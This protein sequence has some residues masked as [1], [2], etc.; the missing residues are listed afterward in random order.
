MG[1]A[2][3]SAKRASQ[4]SFFPPFAPSFGARYLVR[5]AAAATILCVPDRLHHQRVYLLKVSLRNHNHMR[6]RQ[7]L[8]LQPY[9]H[10]HSIYIYKYLYVNS[11]HMYIY[12]YIYKYLYVNSIHMY[13][14]IHTI[15]VY[16]YNIHTYVCKDM[17]MYSKHIS[18]FQGVIRPLTSLLVFAVVPNPL[19][20]NSWKETYWESNVKFSCMTPSIQISDLHKSLKFTHS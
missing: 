5:M 13:I 12:M 2:D 1:A 10:T 8:R 6:S 15:H 19:E 17:F 14:Y 9:T 20:T 4:R 7:L 3:W 16:V 11:I 18:T